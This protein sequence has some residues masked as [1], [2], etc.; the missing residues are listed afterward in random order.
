MV[1]A[2]LAWNT[3]SACSAFRPAK[4]TAYPSSGALDVS[5]MTSIKLILGSQTSPAAL[6]LT[7][8]SG[9]ISL[10]AAEM[11]GSGFHQSGHAS[12]WLFPKALS[13]LTEYV[14]TDSSGGSPVE[15]TR[16]TTAASYDKV[17]GPDVTL[18]SLR[19][20]RVRYPLSC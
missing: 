14:V 16:F 18:T 3:A 4:T 17:Q 5:P 11:M 10:A 9:T 12:F 6:S 15:L 13:P 8:S 2:L 20:W 19:L 7:D 1:L